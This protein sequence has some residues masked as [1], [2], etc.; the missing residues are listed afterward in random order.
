MLL[1][2]EFVHTSKQHLFYF[3]F[4]ILVKKFTGKEKEQYVKKKTKVTFS[5][6]PQILFFLKPAQLLGIPVGTEIGLQVSALD[7]GAVCWPSIDGTGADKPIGRRRMVIPRRILPPRRGIRTPLSNS[8][9]HSRPKAMN[10]TRKNIP[11]ATTF[12][13]LI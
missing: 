10:A 1:L 4:L 13:F 8:P 7:K 9:G 5:N 6:W 12:D 11:K 3:I 2:V